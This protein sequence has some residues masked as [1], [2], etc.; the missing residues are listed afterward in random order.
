MI[1]L[2]GGKISVRD[3]I[4]VPNKEIAG[5]SKGKLIG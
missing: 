1:R 3:K 5:K 4:Q 2:F